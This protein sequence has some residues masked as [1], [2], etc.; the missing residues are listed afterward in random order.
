MDAAWAVDA[1]ARAVRARA[2]RIAT[3]VVRSPLARARVARDEMCAR[4]GVGA[5]RCS[6]TA[7][8]L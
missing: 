6:R 7:L 4:R 3:P 5:A 8:S 2:T 1:E